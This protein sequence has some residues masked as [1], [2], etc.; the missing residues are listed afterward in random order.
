MKRFIATIITFLLL[1]ILPASGFA[2]EEDLRTPV[3]NQCR[4]ITNHIQEMRWCK[5]WDAS[6]RRNDSIRPSIDGDESVVAIMVLVEFIG[7]KGTPEPNVIPEPK[8]MPE[9][10]VDQG[11]I[12]VSTTVVFMSPY[13]GGQRPWLM[14]KMDILGLQKWNVEADKILNYT[15]AKTSEGLREVM[16]SIR[17][18]GMDRSGVLSVRGTNEEGILRYF[19]I[20][21]VYRSLST[22]LL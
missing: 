13:F 8:G 6:L 2:N 18:L 4:A 22:D 10:N 11:K 19:A 17:Y 14:S 7:Q 12:A 15:L 3:F 20:P 21:T 9:L 1:L 5:A 16:K